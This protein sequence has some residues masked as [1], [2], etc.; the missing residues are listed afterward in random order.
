MLPTLGI[1]AGNGY[2]PYE[3]AEL[4][5]KAGGN[6]YIATI[7]DDV[8]LCLYELA[9]IK[10]FSIGY[11]GAILDYFKQN[12]VCNIIMVGGI[13]RPNFNALKMDLVGSALVAKILKQ[14]FLGDDNVL[15]I[16]SAYIENKGF[17]VISP[18]DVL[19][20][21]AEYGSDI[22][23]KICPSPQD[24]IDI[25]LGKKVITSLGH[26]DVGQSVIVADG[27]VLG[28]EA[29][30]GT[31]NLIKRCAVLRKKTK[32][33]VLIKMSKSSQDMRLDI[34]VVGPTTATILSQHGFNGL[35][36]ENKGVIIVQKNQA[37]NLFNEYQLFLKMI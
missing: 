1:I 34:P 37:L 33:G 32:G 25:E 27:Y 22:F 9:Q 26:I 16:I 24:V 14:K 15:K 5:Q 18:Q 19:Q 28:I 6:C 11:A 23:T 35:A 2:L 29:A 7:S 17:N 13:Q 8:D 31:D 21:A 36:I 12:N 3:I 20:I 10:R 4:Y 30:E